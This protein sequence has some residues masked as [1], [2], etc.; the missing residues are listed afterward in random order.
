VARVEGG[1]RVSARS[2]TAWS[3]AAIVVLALVGCGHGAVC[4]PK[5]TNGLVGTGTDT[6]GRT[7]PIR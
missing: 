4:Q 6:G 7:C 1:T 2:R 3:V 5:P